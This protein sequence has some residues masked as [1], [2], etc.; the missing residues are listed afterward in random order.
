MRAVSIVLA[1]I[2]GCALVAAVVIELATGN[3]AGAAW[4][5]AGPT[6]FYVAGLV[7]AFRGPGHRVAAWLLAAG[8]LFMLGVCLGDAVT[9]LPA[10]AGSSF[11]WIAVL[12]GECASG[13]SVV[14]GIGLIG[15]FPT[16]VPDRRGERWV[17]AA[18]AL[19]AGCC[20]AAD[21]AP[22]AAEEL[23]HRRAGHPRPFSGAPGQWGGRRA[24]APFAWIVLR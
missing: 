24:N 20:G 15:L 12:A 19:M 22:D 10:V 4:V 1:V 7:G 21:G 14:A 9:D 6:P 18:A 8:A 17:L 11:A 2:G 3:A 13:A 5:L 23:F 16:G